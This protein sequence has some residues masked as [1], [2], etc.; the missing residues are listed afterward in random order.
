M[1]VAIILAI[2]SASGCVDRAIPVEMTPQ[3]CVLYGQQL[4]VMALQP[5]ERLA[6]WRCVGDVPA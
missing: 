5:G 2:C 6:G 1:I 3:T 4:A